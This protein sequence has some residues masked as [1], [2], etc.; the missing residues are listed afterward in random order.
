MNTKLVV[1]DINELTELMEDVVK[2]VIEDTINQNQF[3]PDFKDEVF[4]RQQAAQFLNVS[5]DKIS[6]MVKKRQIVGRKIGKEYM[7][8]KSELTKALKKYQ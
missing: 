7:I 8:L 3:G 1:V 2:R 6:E 5:P 4:N